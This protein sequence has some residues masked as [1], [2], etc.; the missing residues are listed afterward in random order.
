MKITEILLYPIRMI[1]AAALICVFFVYW[2]LQ[3]LKIIKTKEE[4]YPF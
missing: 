1:A 2:G 4:Y 3:K